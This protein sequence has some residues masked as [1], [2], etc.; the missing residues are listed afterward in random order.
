MYRQ[1]VFTIPASLAGIPVVALPCGFVEGLPVGM[2]LI[3]NHFSEATLFDL[4][5]AYQLETTWHLKRPA[6]TQP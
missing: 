1:D 4:G 5:H 6:G 2:Q 3:G